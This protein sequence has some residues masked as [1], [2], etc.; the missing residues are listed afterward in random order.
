M[1]VGGVQVGMRS[2]FEVGL[3]AELPLLGALGVVVD[4]GLLYALGL[5]GSDHLEGLLQVGHLTDSVLEPANL[6]QLL[7]PGRL[8]LEQPQQS[9]F[10]HAYW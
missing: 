6:N 8:R 1:W 7:H 9:L 5:E 10:S 3:L 2:V 4:L